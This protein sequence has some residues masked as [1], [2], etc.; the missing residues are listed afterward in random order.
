MNSEN[1]FRKKV[2]WL[3]GSLM[4]SLA[5]TAC[6]AQ[7]RPIDEV[8]QVST[9]S[10]SIPTPYTATATQSS[11]ATGASDTG[12]AIPA[13]A[14]ESQDAATTLD[15]TTMRPYSE[16]SIWNTPIVENPSYDLSSPE[17]I[18]TLA[19]DLGGMITSDPN[20]YSYPVYY[21]DES[22]PRWDIPCRKYRC[23]IITP[24]GITKVDVLKNVPI[25]SDARPSAGTDEQM[26]IIDTVAFTEYDLWG[27]ERTD[28][29]WVI[30][31]G[32]IYNILGNG[33]P[34]T[35]GSRGAGVP[36][37]AG[38]IRPWEIDQGRIEHAIAFAYDY[39]AAG[40]CVFPASKTDGKST[41]P[42]SIPEGARLQLD[43]A[44]TESDFDELGLNRTG[45]IIARALQEYGMFLIDNSGRPKIYAENLTA[46]PYE[47]R[48]WS[49]AD[50]GLTDMSIA[51]IPYTFYR[52]LE[53][54]E[55][56]WD[57]SIDSPLH[58]D[59]LAH[60]SD[61]V[62][63]DPLFVKGAVAFAPNN[64][65]VG[66]E[67][68]LTGSGFNNA[69]AVSFGATLV[70]DFIV[71]SDTQ[72]RVTVPEG[73][74]DGPISVTLANSI[75][76]SDNSFVLGTPLPTSAVKV[77]VPV[78]DAQVKST[79]PTRN[80][81]H[82]EELRLRDG[83][84]KHTSYLRFQV[85][86]LDGVVESATV[87]LY[88]TNSSK[89][90][91]SIHLVS[92]EYPGTDTAWIEDSLVWQNAPIISGTPL[93]SVEQAPNDTWIEFD[94]TEAIT[95]DG[96]YSFGLSNNLEISAQ[97]S[98]REGIHPPELVVRMAE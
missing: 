55:G 39:T 96:I 91:G 27:A 23:S 79:S 76:V 34:P 45:K 12:S 88:V 13:D 94:V 59:C 54:P 4:I 30:Q 35:Y 36:Y 89:D 11:S 44:L 73:V 52:V 15:L 65:P 71:D 63:D 83:D 47:I 46:N 24:D 66:S 61:V 69:R 98:S 14:P 3:I 21:I 25:P 19:L 87:R 64:A 32:S 40:N 77:F 2:L 92:N 97:Y 5:L 18:E 26:I 57:P 85:A 33:M 51:S 84:P 6:E 42:Y 82:E 67:V 62:I 78:A 16:N 29:G 60:A 31:N 43:P 22:T 74:V 70:Y 1:L 38:L 20:Q 10:T 7:N 53:L 68:T 93:D 56:Y 41:V 8:D 80:Y 72:I 50:L 37:Y 48:D 49:D 90:G 58:G 75:M 28:T 17:M 9:A 95:G 86:D 81:G